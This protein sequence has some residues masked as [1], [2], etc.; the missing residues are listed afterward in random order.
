M[1][2]GT[3]AVIPAR[4]G[5]KRVPNKN[6]REIGCKPLIAYTIEQAAEADCLDRTIVSTEDEEIRATAEEYG[7]DVP[8]ERPAELATDDA[9]A[10]D[11][12]EHALE[13]FAARDERY[14]E[15]CLLMPTTPFRESDDIDG[16]V[17][18]LRQSDASSVVSVTEFGTPP[19][20]AVT[21]EDDEL[22]PYFDENPWE[23][24]RSQEFPTLYHPN[25]AIFLARV[26]VFV[27]RGEFYTDETVG[28][29]MPRRRSL[30]VD[31]PYDL[32][33]ARALH[34]WRDE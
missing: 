31:E 8:F 16:A 19:N 33:M 28:Y 10:S 22:R 18:K 23:K 1:S 9:T 26:S 14:D 13:W 25:G 7:G 2:E 29:E 11:V 34:A 20:W 32:E 3:L 4:G 15:V 27:E 24:T 5:S 30:D 17:R 12:V 6:V 21:T